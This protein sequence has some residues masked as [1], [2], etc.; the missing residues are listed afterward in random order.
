VSRAC[1]LRAFIADDRWIVVPT[2]GGLVPVVVLPAG[3]SG[4]GR[5]AGG[6]GPGRSCSCIG[7]ALA[8]RGCP[9]SR[10]HKTLN[11]SSVAA[12]AGL[13]KLRPFLRP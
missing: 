1:S 5:P 6:A 13:H 9:R 10:V 2:F 7:V 11:S 4:G 8:R 12:S 3:F